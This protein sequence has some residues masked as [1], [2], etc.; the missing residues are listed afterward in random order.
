[1]SGLETLLRHA[2]ELSE[3]T[4]L[5]TE[6]HQ[7]GNRLFVGI[8]EY[9][10]PEGTSKVARTEILFI[11]DTQYPISA[12]DMFWTDLDVVRTDGTPYENSDSIEEYLGR[13]WRRFSYHRNGIWN[14]AGNP[15]MDHYAFMESRWTGKAKK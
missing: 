12:M 2:A 5:Q 10:M 15:L 14:H 4:G 13:K 11:G 1:M 7:D 8:H 9:V 3:V 6:V